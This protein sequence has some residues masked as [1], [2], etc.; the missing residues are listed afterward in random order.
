MFND[1]TDQ[2]NNKYTHILVMSMGWNNDQ[3]ESL[4]RY[5]KILKNLSSVADEKKEI[6]KPLVIAFTWPSAWATISDSWLKRKIG[7][8]FSYPNKANDADEIG[9]TWANWIVN[10]KLPIA[11]EDANLPDWERPKIVLLGHSF[12]VRLLSR[13]L[14]SSD[15]LNSKYKSNSSVD[16]F[17]GL[18]GAVSGRRFVEKSGREGYP[19]SDFKSLPTKIV[20]TTSVNDKANPFA[21][22]FTGASNVG[23]KQGW[24][25]A[26][27][28]PKV[29]KTETWI[30][31]ASIDIPTDKVLMVDASSIVSKDEDLGLSAHNDVLD[32]EMG[33]L[34]WNFIR[35]LPQVE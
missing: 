30:K 3:V 29:F 23:A 5:K 1:L 4:W 8:I 19:Y 22:Y 14:F 24:R 15:H 11:I 33:E 35:S 10:Y 34:L 26:N 32:K 18:Q 13:A 16:L 12:G 31:G 27:A 6:F 7:H 20:L 9:Y 17:L 2:L 21:H 28:N 25:L